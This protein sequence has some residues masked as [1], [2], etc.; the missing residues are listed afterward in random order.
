MTCPSAP[1]IAQYFKALGGTLNTNANP[2]AGTV[3]YTHLDVYKR[4]EL[5]YPIGL[6]LNGTKP[7]EGNQS[8]SKEN[9]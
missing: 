4:Q 8:N 6:S 3:S 9:H 2:T 1:K 7:P 5:I